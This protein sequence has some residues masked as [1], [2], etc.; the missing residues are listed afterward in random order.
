MTHPNIDVDPVRDFREIDQ[1]L[2]C[3][4]LQTLDEVLNGYEK[5]ALKSKPSRERDNELETMI[6]VW[7]TLTGRQR[8]KFGEKAPEKDGK[9]D[10]SRWRRHCEGVPLRYVKWDNNEAVVIR[11]LNLLTA[12][13]AVAIINMS[14]RDFLRS[15]NQ[16]VPMLKEELAVP[17][18]KY[19]DAVEVA[20]KEVEKMSKEGV[21]YEEEEELT[22]ELVDF[23]RMKRI[24]IPL[25]II[26]YMDIIFYCVCVVV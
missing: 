16:W 15:E 20:K 24:G 22:T 13:E 5:Q 6:K 12:K 25:L 9:P 26:V 7:T 17:Y 4:D 14:P 19:L 2:M 8:P 23:A 1:E 21:D 3:F 18:P 10:I 11:K